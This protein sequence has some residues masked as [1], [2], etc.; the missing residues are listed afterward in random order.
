MSY[1][2]RGYTIIEVMIALA[3]SGIMLMSSIALFRGQNTKAQFDQAM[4]DVNSE[5]TTR[6][7]EVSTSLFAGSENYNCTAAAGSFASITATAGGPKESG[8]EDCIALGKAFHVIPSQGDIYIYSVIGSRYTTC[9]S[10]TCP[11]TSLANAKATIA[12]PGSG[13]SLVQQYSAAGSVKL[14]SSKVNSA[15]SANL[16]G[17]YIDLTGDNTSSNGGEF[18]IGKYYSSAPAEHDNSAVQTCIQSSCSSTDMSLWEMCFSDAQGQKTAK[19]QVMNSSAGAT[20]NL[21]FEACT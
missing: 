1:A 4:A 14:L 13:E 11:V 12:W 10:T 17:Y 20:T 18:L 19:L 3:V 5:I 2:A 8:N 21:K 9:G 7:K 6:L 15:T 16:V